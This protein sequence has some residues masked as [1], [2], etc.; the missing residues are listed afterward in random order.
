M[1]MKVKYM[2]GFV[3]LL[4]AQSIMAQTITGTVTDKSGVPLPGAN[5]IEKGTANGTAT[6]FDGNYTLELTGSDAVLEFS[7]LGFVPQ[8]ITVGS[9]TVLNVTLEEDSQQLGEVLITALGIK[10]EKKAITYSAQTVETE[11]LDQARSLN[12]ANSLSGKVAG[13]NFSTTS[14]GVGSSSRVVL[15]GNR[16]LTGNNQP[17]YVIDG[18]PISSGS[19]QGNPN[20]DTGGLTSSDGISNINPEDIASI[21]VLKG[22]SAAALYGGRA[23]NGVIIITTK[24]GQGA[25]GTR[26]SV[27]SNFMASS[28]YNLLDLQ[29]EYGQGSQG[30]YDPNSQQ[31]WGPR[32]EGQQVSAWQLEHN[33]D[34]DGPAT[35]AF[36]PQPDNGFDFFQTGYTWANTLTATIAKEKTQ[37]YFS[38]TNTKA[39]GIVGG[40][41]L[42]RHNL[43]LRLT[44]QLTD[45]LKLDAKTNYIEQTIDNPLRT[46][47]E[48]VGTAVYLMPRNLPYNQYKDFEYVDAAGQ[49]QY[50]YIDRDAIGAPGGN[51]FWFALRNPLRTNERKRFIGMTSLTYQ[52]SE[53]LSL[54]VRA[55]LDQITDSS[56]ENQYASQAFNNDQGFYREG[57]AEIREF[58]SDFLLTYTKDFNDFALTVLGGGN[59]LQ[60]QSSD[61]SAFG[62]LSRRNFFALENAEDVGASSVYNE[63]VI[64]SL[65]ASANLGY[66]NL[67][68]LDVTARN[69]WSS[70]LPSDNRSYFYPSV[71]L[72]G[73]VSDMVELPEFL[74]FA[75]LRASY[76]QVGS[77]TDPYQLYD[78][79]IY[80]GANGGT[81]SASPLKRNP[82]LLP[83]ISSSIEFGADLRFL[84]NRLGLDFTYFKTNTENQ[85]FRINTA[86]SSGFSQAVVNGGEIEN[87]GIEMILTASPVDTDDFQWDITANFATY[88]SEVLSIRGDRE[89]LVLGDGR[90][91]Q[92]KVTVGG[93]YGDLYI[94]GYA[95]TDD[96]QIIV[97]S[98]GLPTF[99]N[100]FD[101]RAG[102]FNPDWTG[103][104]KNTFNY[105]NFNLSFLIDARIG[106]EVISYTQVRQAGLGVSSR[107]LAFREG[108]LVVDGVQVT[109][110]GAGNIVSTKPNTTSVTAESYWTA[111]A[112]RNARSA[113]DFIYD[114]TNVRLREFVLGYSFPKSVLENS[115]INN[116]NVSLVGRNLFFIVNKAEYFDPE[117]GVGVGNLQ[118][119]E[120]FNLPTTR[121]YGLNVKIGF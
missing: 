55:G 102:N 52:F 88:Q 40:N 6:D 113:E 66:K 80:N 26:I 41:E 95:R 74:S 36:T 50:N 14:N 70:A 77:D 29:N 27:S 51:P 48:S 112:T 33:P 2:L 11:E 81:V 5:V 60:Q 15:R 87:R 24:S 109:R 1:N 104:L 56:I 9:Q 58:N 75:K 120:S 12:V 47:E 116:L 28:A 93:E 65:Y 39:E 13:L 83:E 121:D 82:D 97:G 31:S 103:G 92:S 4:F 105:K 69:D 64:N 117:A 99:T 72:S 62:R 108:G 85:I 71:G 32:M 118:G 67:L 53:E 21:S 94:G 57:K 101:K 76:A 49:L 25:S 114:A 111:V 30:I 19:S 16:S 96:G 18:V 86:N 43:N 17:L 61:L 3:M 106:G 110:D 54:M 37:A 107:T 119:V 23:S 44:S 46:G 38:Y 115:F 45:K 73:V 100:G 89:E 20:A 7:S 63:K 22:P 59:Y 91:V 79:I 35:Y 34:Y 84:K 78:A 42:M 90:L 68:F 8:E 98:D 10:R